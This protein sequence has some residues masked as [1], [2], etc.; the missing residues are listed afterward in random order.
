MGAELPSSDGSENAAPISSI[1]VTPFVDVVLVLLVIFM[2]TAPALM[3]DMIGIQLPKAA[4]SDGSPP[5]SIGVAV[6]RQGQFLLNGENVSIEQ[7][8]EAVKQELIKKPGI[9]AIVSAD[10][11]ALHGDVVKAI[12]TLKNAGLNRFAFQIQKPE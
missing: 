7:L 12:D 4:S 3:K 1:N 11:E 6:T 10:K 2:L 9:Q 8:A 5:E